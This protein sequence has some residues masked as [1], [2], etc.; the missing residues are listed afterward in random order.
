MEV[1]HIHADKGNPALSELE[2]V[3]RE[4]NIRHGRE[5]KLFVS[6]KGAAN[7]SATLNDDQVRVI[8]RRLRAGHVMN[9]IARDY[10]VSP[11]PIYCIK[12]GISW[13]HITGRPK[14]RRPGAISGLTTDEQFG[15]RRKGGQ[16]K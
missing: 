13:T 14:R 3:T 15:G 8:D 6:R 7:P 2:Y 11:Y 4:E 16:P 12:A 10:G 9:Q 5:N 1:N